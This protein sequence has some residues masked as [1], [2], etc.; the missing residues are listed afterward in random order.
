MNQTLNLHTELSSLEYIY[1]HS[2][3]LT[4]HH[5]LYSNVYNK[6]SNIIQSKVISEDERMQLLKNFIDY[7]EREIKF[8]HTSEKFYPALP[9]LVI[10]RT[11]IL[12]LIYDIDFYPEQ[13]DYSRPNIGQFRE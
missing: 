4:D 10:L 13:E 6:Y 11:Q 2:R 1:I 3:T 7:I 9:S 5:S 8:V 12:T